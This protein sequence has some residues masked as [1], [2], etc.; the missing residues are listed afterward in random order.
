M[1]IRLKPKV[2]G[3]NSH[4]EGEV[5]FKETP[6]RTKIGTTALILVTGIP[7]WIKSPK[8]T[9]DTVAPPKKND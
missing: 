6:T 1:Y 2:Q 5:D 4:A 3:N 7:T 9:D 8:P